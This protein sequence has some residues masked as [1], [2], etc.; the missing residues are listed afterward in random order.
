MKEVFVVYN[1]HH[2]LPPLG[3]TLGPPLYMYN[4]S[5]GPAMA[6][7]RS[8]GAPRKLLRTPRKSICL[9]TALSALAFVYVRGRGVTVKLS[10]NNVS[11]CNLLQ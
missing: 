5:L 7:K 11:G 2:W 3:L 10:S 9:W 8:A 6:M 1:S 4:D